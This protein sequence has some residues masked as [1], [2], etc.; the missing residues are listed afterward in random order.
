ML[1]IK[2]NGSY[3]RFWHFE[4][5]EHESYLDFLDEVKELDNITKGYIKVIDRLNYFI[6]PCVCKDVSNKWEINLYRNIMISLGYSDAIIN[7]IVNNTGRNTRP[8]K[9]IAGDG[10]VKVVIDDFKKHIG[11]KALHRPNNKIKVKR[12]E[13]RCEDGDYSAMK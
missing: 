8:L 12:V 4:S 2:I 3:H 13:L 1:K 6:M 9:N 11:V 10:A 7:D 5:P